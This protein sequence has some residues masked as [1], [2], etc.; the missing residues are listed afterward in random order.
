LNKALGK[1]ECKAD[2]T[3]N[4]VKGAYDGDGTI[5][6]LEEILKVLDGIKDTDTIQSIIGKYL[7]LSGGTMLG[8]ITINH[9]ANSSAQIIYKNNR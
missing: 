3:Y 5:E 4:L 8:S 6:N 1:L 2:V 9:D 7:P